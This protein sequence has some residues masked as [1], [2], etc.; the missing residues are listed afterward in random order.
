M[1]GDQG[2][3]DQTGPPSYMDDNEPRQSERKVRAVG[4]AHGVWDTVPPEW[5]EATCLC[6][7]PQGAGLTD[8]QEEFVR[9]TLSLTPPPL[10][11]AGS[12][13]S[14]SDLLCVPGDWPCGPDGLG[15]LVLV[16]SAG[17]GPW[18]RAAV[19]PPTPAVAPVWT[20]PP[21]VLSPAPITLQ[22]EESG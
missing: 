14:L 18:E 2:Q 1:T 13:P 12:S 3:V 10:W 8:V 9:I 5:K 6:L 20:P 21:T 4:R 7:W 11:P 19:W 22:V 16:T 15:S 17:L